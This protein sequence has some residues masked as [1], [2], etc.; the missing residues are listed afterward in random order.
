MVSL[1]I[2]STVRRSG[3]TLLAL[4]MGLK[5]QADGYRV[6]YM[7]PVGWISGQ[8][9]G[10]TS[11]RDA[12]MM[13]KALDLGE[14]L[15]QI[16]PVAM[17]Q[18]MIQCAYDGQDLGVAKRVLDAFHLVRA[19]K[20][21]LLMEGTGSLFEGGFIGARGI[22]LAAALEAM[23]LL[24]DR[25]RDGISTI[26]SLL[27]MKELVG[28]RLVG[29]V[30]NRV[31]GD[32]VS[33]VRKKV[34]HFLKDQEI[35]IM[36][37]IPEDRILGAVSLRQLTEMLSGSAICQEQRLDELV[38]GFMIGAM[39]PENALRRFQRRRNIAVITGG[40]RPDIQ[41]AAL[42]TSVRAII[43]TGGIHPHGIIVSRAD[44]KGVPLILVDQDTF[45]VVEHFESLMGMAA[46][47]EEEKI[48]K[49]AQVV[50]REV[51]FSLLSSKLGFPS[52]GA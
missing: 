9:P 5:L 27:D 21:I 20:D 4:G 32:K 6:G 12:M 50:R 16:C 44:E 8:V 31:Q 46:L 17:N 7:K 52:Q 14:P 42:E 48:A 28:D 37:V 22:E 34:L 3:K 11:D 29:G 1:F 26:D 51:D 13:K 49:A 15:D 2:N 35:D 40:D 25:Y 10:E 30:I 36:G 41:L 18:E 19:H 38:E 45:S 24:V 23:I 39:S 47:R 43:L 33:F